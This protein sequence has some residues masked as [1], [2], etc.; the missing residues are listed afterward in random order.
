MKRTLSV[1]LVIVGCG[2]RLAIR[3]GPEL[4]INRVVSKISQGRMKIIYLFFACAFAFSACAVNET[5]EANST[6]D[7]NDNKSNVELQFL[8][9]EGCSNTPRMME[10]LKAAIASGK[11]PAQYVVVQQAALSPDDPRTGYPTPTILMEG[12]DI[13]DLPVPQ[14]PYPEPS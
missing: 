5:G 2:V 8:T 1:S 9:R 6:R 13:F 11:L 14:Q 3:A 7:V 4:Y 10:N 12:K